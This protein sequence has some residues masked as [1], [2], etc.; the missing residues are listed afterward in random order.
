MPATTGTGALSVTAT[1]DVTGTN[2]EGIY[3]LTNTNGT[4]LTVSAAA[5]SGGT[6]GIKA[7]NFGTGALSV[8]STGDV[9]A[10]TASGIFALNDTS[11][12]DLTVS[13]AAVSGTY[14]IYAGNYGTGALSVTATGAVT[15]TNDYGIR[16]LGYGTDLTISAAAVSGGTDGILA[17]NEGTGALSVTATGDVTGTSANGIFARNNTNGTDLTISA[18]AVSGGRVGIKAQN[19]GTGALSVTSTGDVT[20][21]TASGIFALND[22]S[23][24]DLTVSAAAVSGT[25]GIYAG[26]YGTGALSVTATGAVSG[27]TGDGIRAL[28]YGTDLTVSAAAVS[29][30]T[31]GIF[32]RNNGTGTLS[33]TVSGT[34]S[35]GANGISTFSTANSAVAITLQSTAD[36]TGASASIVDGDGDAVVTINTGA[37]ISG[38]ISLGNGNDTLTIADGVSLDN[39][40][41]LS[42]GS[43]SGSTDTLN[44]STSFAGALTDWEVIN[45]NGNLGN[46]ALTMAAGTKLGGSGTLGGDIT[47]LD[48]ATLA[49]GNSP[50]TLTLGSLNLANASILEFELGAAGTPGGALNDLVIVN[51]NL[52]LDGVLNVSQSA[53]GD[54]STGI[55]QLYQYGGTLT[56]NTLEFGSALPN[57]HSGIVQAG[58]VAGQVN[59]IVTGTPSSVLY[60]DNDAGIANGLLS[61]GSGTWD[62]SSANWAG[63]VGSILNTNWQST[64]G[65]FLGTAGTVS[66]DG[67]QAFEILQFAVDGYTLNSGTAGSLTTAGTG[68]LFVDTG[69]NATIN[70]PITG[71]GALTKQGAGTLTLG[72]VNT[73]AGGT[74][75]TAGTLVGDVTSFG[76]GAITNNAAL[77]FDQATDASFSQVISGTGALTKQGAGTL[78]LGGVNTFAGGT[79]ITTG[80]LVGDV[81]SFGSGAITNNAALV[82]DQATDASFSQVI[83][84]T[85]ALTKQ[86]A[87][88]LTLGGVNTFAGGTSV[89]QG[90]LNVTGSLANSAVTVLSDATLLGTGTLGNL[91]AQSGSLVSA[92][93]SNATLTVNGALTLAAGSTLAVDISPTGAGLISATGTASIAGNLVVTPGAGNYFAQSFT[94]VSSSAL[95]GTF[96]AS[97]LGD[98]GTSFRASLIYSDTSV[99]LRLD[100]NSLIS[101][102]G[103][104]L[105][106]NALAVAGS[107][108]AAVTDGYNP[109]PFFNL[110]TLGDAAAPAL[111]SL[112]GEMRSTE[113]RVLL[114]G[115][116]AVREAA[117]N[118]LATASSASAGT[119]SVVREDADKS[120][121]IW[122]RT[123]GAWGTASA[124]SL[125]ERFTTE[126]RSLMSGI[127]FAANGLKLGGMLYQSNT[128]VDALVQGHSRIDS[129]GMALYG[130]YRQDGSGFAFGAGGSISSNNAKGDRAINVPGLSQ[131]LISK[132]DSTSYQMFSE[133]SFDLTN[134]DNSQV[135]P[136][137]RAAYAKVKTR[138]FSE[139][140][141]IAAVSGDSQ[142]SDLTIAM[143][144]MRAAYTNGMVSISG[145]SAWQRTMGDRAVSSLQSISGVGALYSVSTVAFDRDALA[146]EF[147]TTVNLS[148]RIVLGAGYSSLLGKNNSEHSARATVRY[149]F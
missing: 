49:P 10:T 32:A 53:G 77:V 5:V 22:T 19:D 127:D 29:G 7:R 40:A 39:V 36:V 149:A 114:D 121:T 91:T 46:A 138:S 110:Y 13:A 128:D 107:F 15:G 24:T 41:T 51:G 85:G 143:L 8:T 103:D 27:T 118:R 102:A 115:T 78:T 70:A 59:L 90:T 92:G 25:Y 148:Q 6:Y 61:G 30:G 68:V 104:T 28:G 45:V 86:G 52:V 133:V 106:G 131:S 75:I 37:L 105:S 48:G 109:Q 94:L 112:S 26:N 1:G 93:S 132:V 60:W 99:V 65:V 117:F 55:Y 35:A 84:G 38:A 64:V 20:A 136:F 87:G 111:N 21:T 23:G 124:D 69:A 57:G 134:A 2:Y 79:T 18:A 135:E 81:T 97:T 142:S 96:A 74:T 116:R 34:V 98:F 4:D 95:T 120:T 47:V 54:F 123:A 130:G 141:G 126:Q 31:D 14:G 66:I 3:A 56:D 137:L 113:R 108:D 125:G 43:E 17:R 140:G 76:S 44:I 147:E 145:S 139:S 80:T 9:T 89:S 122:L 42:G 82:F 16:A 63:G 88:T 67:A 11:G 100:P 62:A 58:L 50:G 83:S 33:V 71:T 146:M 12:T 129:V 101:V 119:Q 73:F 144:G 72:G